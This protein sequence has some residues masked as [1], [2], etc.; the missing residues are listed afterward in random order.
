[1][2]ATNHFPDQ[3]TCD[4]TQGKSE[5]RVARSK[6]DVRIAWDS[7]DDR[8]TIWRTGP[9]ATPTLDILRTRNSI[10]YL[11]AAAKYG[12]GTSFIEC[13]VQPRKLHRTGESQS[14]RHRC[15]RHL[16]LHV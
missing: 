3:L 12:V 11:K 6:V 13:K 5:H 10:D 8:E 14:L 15:D 2:G 1:M 7:A 4:G 9:Q 16:L